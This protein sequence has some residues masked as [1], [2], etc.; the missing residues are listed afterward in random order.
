MNHVKGQHD[1][2]ERNKTEEA[3]TSKSSCTSPITFNEDDQN[4]TYNKLSNALPG[5]TQQFL[6]NQ[7]T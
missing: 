2:A 4:S 7:H 1:Q 6:T 3:Q 5:M